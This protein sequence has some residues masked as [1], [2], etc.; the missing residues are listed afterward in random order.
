MIS[1]NKAKWASC[2]RAAWIRVGALGDLLVGLA[3]LQE[4]HEF[5]PA[6]QVLVVGPKLWLEILD[7][8]MYP[9]IDRI[10]VVEKKK[11]VA[12]VFKSNGKSWAEDVQQIQLSELLTDFD[13][14]VNTNIDSLR[15]GIQA[16]RAGV[17]NRVGSASAINSALYTHCSPFFGKDPLIHE[18]DAALLIL[19]Y[20]TPGFSKFFRTLE[21]NRRNLDHWI[22]SSQLVKKWN[23]AGLPKAKIPD[24]E[25]TQKLVG[26]SDYVLINPTSSRREKAWPADK[27]LHLIQ[28]IKP[29]LA[30]SKIV[31]VVIGSTQET[32]WL[33]EV[34]GGET[35]RAGV[36]IVQPNSI[37]ELQD[38]VHFARAL[39]TNTSSMQFVA[40]SVGTKTLTLM[41]RARPEI[42]G[43]LG[44]H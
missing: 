6:A 9:W 3:S 42:W 17:K 23:E 21:R 30:A 39:L 14:V 20:A 36:K 41:G 43:P 18:R 37:A 7:P 24:R 31:P 38:V 34:A 5:F 4:M 13:A 26:A 2:Q 25:R 22:Q 19:E 27:F 15:Y 28:S 8:Q 44:P 12:R 10:A 35:E 1:D 11:T 16:F 33:L 29:I 32:D 40:A